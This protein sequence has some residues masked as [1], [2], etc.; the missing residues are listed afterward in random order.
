[1]SIQNATGRI[2]FNRLYDGDTLILRT[3][4][5]TYQFTLLDITT[6]RGVL[7]GNSFGNQSFTAVLLNP[8]E[9]FTGAN[10]R[11]QI[12]TAEGLVY[13]TTSPLN[14]LQAIC[15]YENASL[16]FYPTVKI[17]GQLAGYSY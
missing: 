15:N 14:S 6:R 16:D 4:N 10:I 5:S 17:T 9:L 7:R 12:Q 11:F 13:M 3:Q 1:M 2:S 8:F